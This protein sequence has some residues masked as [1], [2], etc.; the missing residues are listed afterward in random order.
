MV[1]TTRN[2]APVAIEGG[3][4]E[5]RMQEV[6]GDMTVAF[7]RLPKGTDLAPA[8]KGL[9]GDLCQCPHWGYLF[10]GR[11]KMRTKHGDEIYEAGQAFY[12][13]PGHAPEALEDCEYMDFSPT[14]EFNEVID[15][16]KSQMG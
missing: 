13:A 1:A 3:G 15:H 5:L 11:L 8:V 9:P 16:V 12:W 10:K 7:A 14:K 2:D 4:V 6:G